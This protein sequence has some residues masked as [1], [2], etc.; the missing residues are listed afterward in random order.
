MN[1]VFRLA[2]NCRLEAMLGEALTEVRQQHES[3]S[4]PAR[5]FRELRYQTRESWSRERRGR[6]ES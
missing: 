4:Q 6:R 2:R 3:T 1:Y 5:L